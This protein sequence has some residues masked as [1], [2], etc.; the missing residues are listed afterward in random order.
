MPPRIQL[1]KSFRFSACFQQGERV[2]GHNYVLALSVDA[3]EERL[4]ARLEG[5]VDRVLIRHLHTRDLGRDVHFIKKGSVSD[6]NLL[7]A[8]HR[9]L[10]RNRFPFRLRSL[11]LKRD[12]R[13]I[14]HLKLP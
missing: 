1:T 11:E 9:E 10:L 8:F 5:E 6:K 7:L 14:T 3:P 2:H 4:E 13:T 12:D